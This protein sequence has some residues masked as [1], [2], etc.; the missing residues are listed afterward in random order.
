MNWLILEVSSAA[1]VGSKSCGDSASLIPI[2]H[3]Q[4]RI[5]FWLDD[6]CIDSMELFAG[7][8]AQGP[9]KSL[10]NRLFLEVFDLKF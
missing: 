3:C 1:H 8:S 10:V 4:W 6:E 7:S 9:L 2:A 5:N